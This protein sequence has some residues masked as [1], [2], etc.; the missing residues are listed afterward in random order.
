M[1]PEDSL[2]H[3][4]QPATCPCANLH[5]SS[6]CFPFHFLKIHINF[7]LP[8]TLRSSKWEFSQLPLLTSTLQSGSNACSWLVFV[9]QLSVAGTDCSCQCAISFILYINCHISDICVALLV[10]TDCG[11][12]CD[13]V[14]LCQSKQTY[15]CA[16][17]QLHHV[18]W[19][20]CVRANRPTGVLSHHHTM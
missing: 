11:V 8:S 16:V 1:E 9:L 17:T 10:A 6:P 3:S 12:S 5:Q 20:V 19:W 4:Q 7:I 18:M 14:C 13:V 2:P 15:W